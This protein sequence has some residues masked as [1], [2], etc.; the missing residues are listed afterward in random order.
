MKKSNKNLELCL[1]DCSKHSARG[2]VQKEKFL[3]LGSETSVPTPGTMSLLF[4]HGPRVT[5][6][7]L[8]GW[9][10][11]Q[12]APLCCMDMISSS[13]PPLVEVEGDFRWNPAGPS[14]MGSKKTIDTPLPHATGLNLVAV[15][16]VNHI[17]LIFF[18][19]NLGT[20]HSRTIGHWSLI[21]TLYNWEFIRDAMKQFDR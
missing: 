4:T 3:G 2:S 15:N 19:N 10:S 5:S 18:G 20:E 11:T 12:T 9:V 21:L 8:V 14:I 7:L 16:S 17:L 6:P 1:F 13:W